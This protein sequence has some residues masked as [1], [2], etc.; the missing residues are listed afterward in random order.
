MTD[1]IGLSA[2]HR[3]PELCLSEGLECETCIRMSARNVA[4]LT[5]ALTPDGTKQIF[6]VL[7]P[8][9]ECRAMIYCFEKAYRE[10][11]G[12]TSPKPIMMAP[13]RARMTRIAVA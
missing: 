13:S 9:S 4:Y 1:S 5:P 2:H 11:A 12:A 10:V 6:Q 7:Y 8:A 3:T